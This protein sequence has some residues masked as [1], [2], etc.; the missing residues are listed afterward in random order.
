MMVTGT[1]FLILYVSNRD[2]L[3]ESGQLVLAACRLC[4]CP[5]FRSKNVGLDR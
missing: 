1:G 2:A 5:Y 4:V 3:D